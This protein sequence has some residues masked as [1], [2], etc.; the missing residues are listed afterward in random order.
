MDDSF[1]WT[2]KYLPPTEKHRSAGAILWRNFR[3]FNNSDQLGAAM[4]I[5]W[6]WFCNDIIDELRLL[7]S[8]ERSITLSMDDLLART[9]AAG[10]EP[11]EF[12]EKGYW[13]GALR[14][15]GAWRAA[16]RA[17]LSISLNPAQPG[18]EVQSITFRLEEPQTYR[19]V[20]IHADNSE[21]VL[22]QGLT[23]DEASDL[24]VKLMDSSQYSGFKVEAE[25]SGT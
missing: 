8:N 6:S 18:A 23:R 21:S 7:P 15:R 13:A 16:R 17:G 20:G 22:G 11:K 3:P 12:R 9:G 2:S 5:N 24:F 10:A 1:A 4:R 14:G 25:R 19:I